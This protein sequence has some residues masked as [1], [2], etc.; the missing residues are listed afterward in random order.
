LISASVAVTLAPGTAAPELSRTVPF[1]EPN[2][3][4]ADAGTA[5]THTPQKTISEKIFGIGCLQKARTY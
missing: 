3:C 4:C 1:R 5:K 2:V